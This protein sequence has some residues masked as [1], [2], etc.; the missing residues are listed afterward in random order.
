MVP[1]TTNQ[2]KATIVAELYTETVNSVTFVTELLWDTIAGD[3]ILYKH[4]WQNAMEAHLYEYNPTYTLIYYQNKL[5]AIAISASPPPRYFFPKKFPQRIQLFLEYAIGRACT[6]Y[7]P[8]LTWSQDSLF[9]RDDQTDP[10]ILD[11]ILDL[12]SQQNKRPIQ[13]YNATGGS[14]SWLYQAFR[15]RGYAPFPASSFAKLDLSPY[16]TFADYLQHHLNSKRRRE[17]RRQLRRSVER[18]IAVQTNPI[19]QVPY[20]NAE[21][22]QLVVSVI[23]HHQ[24]PEPWFDMGLFDTLRTVL[25]DNTML[26]MGVVEGRLAG[27]FVGLQDKTALHLVTLGLD[28]TIAHEHRIYFL[29]HYEVIRY[30]IDQCLQTVYLGTTTLDVKRRLGYEVAP[31]YYFMCSHYWLVD[32][33]LRQL[34]SFFKTRGPLWLGRDLQVTNGD[35]NSNSPM[36]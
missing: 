6:Y 24:L 5:Q 29:L 7:A 19:R 26:F 3:A 4:R 36:T 35:N 23:A 21:L 27:F 34:T 15:R 22:Y 2:T 10:L 18:N 17:I 12:L 31:R 33:C 14:T 1:P 28:Y 11:A 25:A 20:T 9:F 32:A 16:K 13:I 30:A 8:P